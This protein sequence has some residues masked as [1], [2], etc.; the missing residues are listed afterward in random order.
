MFHIYHIGTKKL[1]IGVVILDKI[2]IIVPIYN[3][4]QYVEK[5]ITSL[6]NQTYKNIEVLA[7]IDG[8]PDNSIDIVKKMAKKDKRVKFYEKSNGG[9][10]SVLEYAISAI[11]SKYFIVCD[12]DDWLVDTAIEDLYKNLKKYDVDFV[13]GDIFKVYTDNSDGILDVG[14]HKS[15]EIIPYYKYNNLN[16]FYFF[17]P[18]PHAK[19]FK[20]EIAKK[21]RFPHNVSYTDNILYDVYL[22]K[23][24]SGVY[25]N[26][27][28]AY[29]FFD[30]PGNSMQDMDKSNYQQ[31]TFIATTVVFN[32]IFEQLNANLC[33]DAYAYYRIHCEYVSVLSK[34]KWLDDK[35]L[36]E[37]DRKKLLEYV[38]KLK[39]Y[40][41]SMR[42][43]IKDKNLILRIIKRFIFELV[44]LDGIN[45][46]FS[47]LYVKIY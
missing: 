34:L 32:S 9:Y 19:L 38:I 16:N 20:T 31:K 39:K 40:K 47:K 3:V 5:C 45:V 10:G 30:R 28:L 11:D 37:Q 35:K 43:C 7:V 29:Y 4:E 8:S 27:P 14:C 25:V 18:T 1:L 33:V 2:S 24:K 44:Y 22:S 41:K 42:K 13:V 46:I 6:L 23:S 21:I 17:R 15:Y 26:K 36:I 12:P